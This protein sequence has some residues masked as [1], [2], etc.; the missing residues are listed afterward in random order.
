M[1]VPKGKVVAAGLKFE[2]TPEDR[3]QAIA[4]GQV[5]EEY[6]DRNRLLLLGTTLSNMPLHVV[7][8]CT[9]PKRATIVS[10]YIPDQRYWEPGWRTRKPGKPYF[11][12]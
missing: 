3:N 12:D 11:D 2:V 6:P 4:N 7:V 8:E 10:L 9:S 1:V 5:I